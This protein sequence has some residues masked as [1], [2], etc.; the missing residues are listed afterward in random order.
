MEHADTYIIGSF[1]AKRMT[2]DD[3]KADIAMREL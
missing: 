2:L 3:V 1:S